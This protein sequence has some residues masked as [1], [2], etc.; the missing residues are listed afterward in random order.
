[1]LISHIMQPTTLEDQEILDLISNP[2]SVNQGF[3]LLVKKYQ[4]RLYQQVRRMVMS[5]DDTDDVLQLVFIKAWKNIGSF[6]GDSKLY[7]WLCRIAINESITFLNA[8]K[9]RFFVSADDVQTGLM[10]TADAAPQVNGD[11]IQQKLVQAIGTLPDKQRAVFNLKYFD[12]MPYEEMSQ[13]TG[14]SVGALKASY[15]HA[16]QKIEKFLN[17]GATE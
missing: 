2:D 4:A 11:F 6:R 16:V 7:T 12:E 17:E 3:N 10:G 14:T 9:K 5:H 15:H 8:K 13:I 1:L